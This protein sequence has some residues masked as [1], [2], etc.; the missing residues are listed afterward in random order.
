M[1]KGCLIPALICILLCC[2][3]LYSLLADDGYCVRATA[4]SFVGVKEQGGNNMGFND[5]ALLILMKQQGWK[6]GYAW[7]SFYRACVIAEHVMVYTTRFVH[8]I[9]TYTLHDGEK[10]KA[11]S[12][13]GCCNSHDGRDI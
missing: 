7:C 1:A 11:L 5:K 12:W 10:D 2:I 8:L 13:N 3:P 4:S 6:P 9:K